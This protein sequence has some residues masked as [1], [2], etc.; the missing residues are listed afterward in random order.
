MRL[1]VPMWDQTAC[2]SSGGSR[3]GPEHGT[4]SCNANHVSARRRDPLVSGCD[5]RASERPSG[6]SPASC[7][8]H[9]CV[10]VDTEERLQNRHRTPRQRND[11]R[12]RLAV[13]QPTFFRLQIPVISAPGL[14]LTQTTVSQHQATNGST[15]RGR[16]QPFRSNLVQGLDVGEVEHL[17]PPCDGPV[18]LIGRAAMAMRQGR[19]MRPLDR[20]DLH[21]TEFGRDELPDQP[22][23]CLH[24]SRFAP[25]GDRLV[26]GACCKFGNPGTRGRFG[27]GR[28]GIFTGRDAGKDQGGLLSCLSGR[29]PWRSSAMF[30]CTG[31]VQCGP[32]SRKDSLGRRSQTAPG[33]GRQCPCRRR[34]GHRR[35]VWRANGTAVLPSSRSLPHSIP[36]ML[37]SPAVSR[38]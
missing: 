18:R 21:R 23:G 7:R 19:E 26:Q 1:F 17:P 35:S 30:R 2:R 4:Q 37:A 24:G 33:P 10:G 12:P 15:N 3:R 32:W 34:T 27:R 14:D 22:P 28:I 16:C 13:A 36:G 20:P 11:P 5:A 25:A 6:M 9:S 38:P 8:D 29:P 31:I